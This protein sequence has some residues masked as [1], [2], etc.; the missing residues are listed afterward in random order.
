MKQGYYV[1]VNQKR[2]FLGE[3]IKTL[4]GA[5][6]KAKQIHKSAETFDIFWIDA[7]NDKMIDN[8]H[9]ASWRNGTWH[10]SFIDEWA[11]N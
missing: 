10:G 4:Q 8:Y 7:E 3:N 2:E 6:I 5:K 11:K 9:Q 1:V